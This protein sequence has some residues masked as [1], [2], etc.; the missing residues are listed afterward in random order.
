MNDPFRAQNHLVWATKIKSKDYILNERPSRDNVRV[1]AGETNHKLRLLRG[2]TLTKTPSE[3]TPWSSA[4]ITPRVI[5]R[6]VGGAREYCS[7]SSLA[8]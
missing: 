7:P 5:T 3:S 6:R 1:N 2:I 8:Q 4:A